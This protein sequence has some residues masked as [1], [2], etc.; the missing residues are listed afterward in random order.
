VIA[1]TVVALRSWLLKAGEEQ[2]GINIKLDKQGYSIRNCR[3][4]D[5]VAKII[6]QIKRK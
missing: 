4:P 2:A 3:T 6:R 5:D 1:T